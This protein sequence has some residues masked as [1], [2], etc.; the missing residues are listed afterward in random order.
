[1]FVQIAFLKKDRSLTICPLSFQ[2]IIGLKEGPV[3]GL[4]TASS[5]KTHARTSDNDEQDE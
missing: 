3:D 1:M 5:S 2:L 4:I